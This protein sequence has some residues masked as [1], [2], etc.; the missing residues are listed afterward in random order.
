MGLKNL[1]SVCVYVCVQ[2][3]VCVCESV[4]LC[5]CV[6]V[7]VCVSVS[8]SVCIC[9]NINVVYDNNDQYEISS[10]PG[11]FWF[12]H[13]PQDI[14]LVLNVFVDPAVEVIR[15]LSSPSPFPF[16]SDL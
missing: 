2:A 10:K 16:L 12:Y 8:V 5:V 13:S 7:C 11:N 9:V 6:C 4:C 14:N 1:Y 15:V 3:C